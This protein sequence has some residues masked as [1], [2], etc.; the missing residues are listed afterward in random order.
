MGGGGVYGLFGEGQGVGDTFV[1]GGPLA[2][3]PGAGGI[4]RLAEDEVEGGVVE[5]GEIGG[6]ALG[7]AEGAAYLFDRGAVS[8]LRL[9]A[10]SDGEAD[11]A[12]EDGRLAEDG[13]LDV[14]RVGFAVLPFTEVGGGVG[15]VDAPVDGVGDEIVQRGV[16]FGAPA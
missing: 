11:E 6:E 2:E 1:P 5:V 16:A 13:V 7:G 14:Y 3:E 9:D 15:F 8:A 4:G 12:L 10:G